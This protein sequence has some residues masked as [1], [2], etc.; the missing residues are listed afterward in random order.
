[1]FGFFK[2]DPAGKL[3]KEIMKKMAISVEFQRNGKIKEFAEAS[4]EISDLQDE[5]DALRAGS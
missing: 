1:M 4:K 2:K 5:L 3:E